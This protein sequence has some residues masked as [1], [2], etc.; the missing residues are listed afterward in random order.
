MT[1]EEIIEE[2]HKAYDEFMDKP[3]KILQIF[4]DFFGEDKVDM[5]GYP[6]FEEILNGFDRID[7][8]SM[9]SELYPN[10]TIDSILEENHIIEREILE[11]PVTS[12]SVLMKCIFPHLK[13]FIER[14]F[15]DLYILVHFPSVRVTNEYGRYIDIQHLYAKV[16]F[17]SDGKGKG[18][19]SLNRSEYPLDQ[20]ICGYMHSHINII[21]VNNFTAF[22][23]PCT[24]TG[25]INSTLSTL[26]CSF[27]ESI[28]QLLCVELDKYVRVES[29]AGV[30]YNRLENVSLNFRGSTYHRFTLNSLNGT[31]TNLRF[32]ATEDGKNRKSFIK[33]L[34]ESNKLKFN[35]KNGSYS[36]AM[37]PVE[38][39]ITVSDAFIDWANKEYVEGRFG[40][41]FNYFLEAEIL[42]KGK[43]KNDIIFISGSRNVR[44]SDYESHIGKKVCTFKGKDVNL[45]IKAPSQE[46]SNEVLFLNTD[47]AERILNSVL[48]ILNSKY[49]RETGETNLGAG[50]QK[51]CI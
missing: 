36:I 16:P 47:V 42:K 18:Y 5:Q 28:W 2:V 34:L 15:N 1:R 51:Y 24:G 35:F 19:F 6:P 33:Y 4:E 30:P 40:Y 38:Y 46:D 23:A 12:E 9:L 11:L 39:I 44:L 3:R 43:V 14:T 20:F 7:V 25:P 10:S 37:S 8:R 31:S 50:S 41:S 21:P 48:L 13:K 22:Q 27:D 29:I 26:C 49:G 32:F 17:Y 45:V